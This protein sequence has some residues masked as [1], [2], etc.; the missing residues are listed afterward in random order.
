MVAP[1]TRLQRLLRARSTRLVFLAFAV[2][3]ALVGLAMASIYGAA[4]REIARH[5]R[6]IIT[7]LRDD[8]VAVWRA[9]GMAELAR[10]IDLRSGQFESGDVLLLADRD[11]NALAG[12]IAGIPTGSP[13]SDVWQEAALTG[14]RLPAG[15]YLFVSTRLDAG[16]VLIAGRARDR[17]NAMLTAIIEALVASLALTIPGALV[18]AILLGRLSAAR[19]SQIASVAMAVTDG[20]MALRAPRDGSEDVYDRLAGVINRMLDRIEQL[21]D[22]LRTVTDGLAHDL[23]SPLT[24]LRG[25]VER[26]QAAGADAQTLDAMAEDLDRLLA[27]LATALQISRAEA[28]IGRDHFVVTDVADLLSDTVDVYGPVAEDHGIAMVS[29]V[30]SGLACALHRPLIQQAL[31][32]A[33]ENALRHATGATSITLSANAISDGVELVVAD[34]G[35]GIPPEKHALALSRFGRLDPARGE[36]ATEAGGGMGL[37]LALV[38]AVARLHGGNVVLASNAPGLKLIIRLPQR[39]EKPDLPPS[40]PAVH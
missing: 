22:E 30:P 16:H 19:I 25:R 13:M 15:R 21:L 40:V 37:G 28:G 31:G 2:Q 11:G 8:L 1:L 5:D 7:E 10:V 33:I 17:G 27:M 34:D 4:S 18:L 29:Q 6:A 20:N 14:P 23:R 26:A 9:G 12:N 39:P 35:P 24:R 38:S 32:N 3:L 36:S